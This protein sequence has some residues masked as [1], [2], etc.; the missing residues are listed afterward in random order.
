MSYPMPKHEANSKNLGSEFRVGKDPI[1]GMTVE[2]KRAAAKI[3]HAGRSYYFCSSVVPHVSR[4]S[5]ENTRRPQPT[6]QISP[7]LAQSCN[8]APR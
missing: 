1:C 7:T 4:N 6:R 5:P 2:P 8:Q 3:D